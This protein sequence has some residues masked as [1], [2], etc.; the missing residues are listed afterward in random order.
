[1]ANSYVYFYKDPT[2][3]VT[4][5]EL[6]TDSGYLSPPC[7]SVGDGATCNIVTIKNASLSGGGVS[8]GYKLLENVWIQ[9]SVTIDS[10]AFDPQATY[11]LYERSSIQFSGAVPTTPPKIVARFNLSVLG[12]PGG[13]SIVRYQHNNSVFTEFSRA[14]DSFDPWPIITGSDFTA[15]L[16]TTW[17]AKF[18]PD[19]I[20][21]NDWGSGVRGTPTFECQRTG[22]YVLHSNGNGGIENVEL[23]QRDQYA[24]YL[25]VTFS[26]G[27]PTTPHYSEPSAAKEGISGGTAAAI[28]LGVILAVVIVAVVVLIVLGKLVFSHGSDA[29]P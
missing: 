19:S 9:G 28:A 25:K 22:A 8:Y 20:I 23:R 1:M 3:A 14:E 11:Y 4:V 18:T 13:S 7:T 17:K 24:L 21:G 5:N 6:E 12:R 2:T 16:C 10:S 27:D 15:E 26:G 29:D